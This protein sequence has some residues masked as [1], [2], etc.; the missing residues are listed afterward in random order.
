MTFIISRDYA[1]VQ[2]LQTS[3]S[4]PVSFWNIFICICPNSEKKKKKK[5]RKTV[6]EITHIHM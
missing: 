5:E 4:D 1:E 3:E 2:I 6:K